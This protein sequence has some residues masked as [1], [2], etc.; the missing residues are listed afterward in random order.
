MEQSL[1]KQHE[2]ATLQLN[3]AYSTPTHPLTDFLLHSWW[4]VTLW[5][6]GSTLLLSCLVMVPRGSP[7]GDDVPSQNITSHFFCNC[8]SALF[9]GATSYPSSVCCLA[10][11]CLEQRIQGYSARALSNFNRPVYTCKWWPERANWKTD[12]DLMFLLMTFSG[13]RGLVTV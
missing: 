1:F 12:Y 9:L 8:P 10:S 7:S 3:D 4:C 13:R 2:C 11:G 6:E 5:Q